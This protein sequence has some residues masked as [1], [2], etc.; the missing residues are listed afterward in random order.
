MAISSLWRISFVG[1]IAWSCAAILPYSVGQDGVPKQK[2]QPGAAAEGDDDAPPYTP[3]T[4]AQWKKQLTGN[5]FNVTRK[6][7]T[8]RA[9]SGE[10]WKTK[11][12]GLYR[13]VC[14]GL[15]LF[16][17]ETKF[18][19]GTGWPS[20][21]MPVKPNNIGTEQD[22]SLGT[23]RTEVHCRRC[24]AHL[25][26]VFQDGPAPT[27]LRFCINSAS[28]K[29][30]KAEGAEAGKGKGKAKGKTTPTPKRQCEP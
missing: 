30:E 24:S 23:V 4:E 8:E 20:F 21:Y 6:K 22:N 17:S 11:D 13:C 25:G 27:G 15:P 29:L 1:L 7:A 12:P 14:C 18:E 16:S 5:Q 26:H 2:G 9:F 3:K 10:Y 19:S 28:L